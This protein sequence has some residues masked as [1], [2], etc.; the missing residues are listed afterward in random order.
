MKI[1]MSEVSAEQG[2]VLRRHVNIYT[3]RT[4]LFHRTELGQSRKL[5]SF[6]IWTFYIFESTH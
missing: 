4:S 6:Y 1:V 2:R 3:F 5:H